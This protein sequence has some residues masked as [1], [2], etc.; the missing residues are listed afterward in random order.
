MHIAG[1]AVCKLLETSQLLLLTVRYQYID[2]V[3]YSELG[4]CVSIFDDI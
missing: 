3:Y 1:G 2:R 4:N